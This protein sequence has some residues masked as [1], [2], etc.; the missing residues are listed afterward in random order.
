MFDM[1][2]RVE[3]WVKNDHLG[4]VVPYRNAG[5]RRDYLPDFIVRLTDG[6]Y[7]VIEIKGLIRD[8][9]VKAT[10]AQRWCAAVTNDGRFERWTYHLVR[11]PSDLSQVLERQPAYPVARAA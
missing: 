5:I 7:L 6:Q 1:H 10:A 9:D 4:F 3:T 8:G 11:H 2:P